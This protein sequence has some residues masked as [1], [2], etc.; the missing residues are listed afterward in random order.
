M[1]VYNPDDEEW[2][3]LV[4]FMASALIAWVCLAAFAHGFNW[5]SW[6]EFPSF[7]KPYM[8]FNPMA[9]SVLFFLVQATAGIAAWLVWSEGH[10]SNNVPPDPENGTIPS[11][12]EYFWANLVWILYFGFGL[13][14]GPCFFTATLQYNNIICSIAFTALMLGISGGL[15][16]VGWFIWFVPGILF[17]L[18]GIFWLFSFICVCLFAR[19]FDIGEIN[20]PHQGMEYKMVQISMESQSN[21]NGWGMS[22]SRADGMNEDVDNPYGNA[23]TRRKGRRQ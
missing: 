20:S 19:E 13:F 5:K 23:A 10:R 15:A 14:F 6:W 3:A 22:N 1:V 9:Y 16:I 4:I 2:I 18:V 12:T 17:T 8:L 11:T 21:S 7:R